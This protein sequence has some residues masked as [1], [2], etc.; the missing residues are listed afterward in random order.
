[1]SL[2]SLLPEIKFLSLK[3][4]LCSLMKISYDTNHSL[5]N[6]VFGGKQDK[7]L[8]VKLKKKVMVERIDK[9]KMHD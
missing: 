5:V 3:L 8:V 2:F 6:F 7:Q 1:M 4:R 9:F